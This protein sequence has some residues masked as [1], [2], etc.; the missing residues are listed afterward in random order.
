MKNIFLPRLKYSIFF[1]KELSHNTP[2]QL[3][4]L[5]DNY[6][7]NL[8]IRLVQYLNSVVL[9][10]SNTNKALGTITHIT[11]FKMSP[12]MPSILTN[13]HTKADIKQAKTVLIAIMHCLK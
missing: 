10:E 4:I 8:R 5:N 9:Q 2:L 1:L 6:F 7:F 11:I 13:E 12:G 3:Q